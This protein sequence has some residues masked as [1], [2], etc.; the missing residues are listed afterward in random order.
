MRILVVDDDPDLRDILAYLLRRKGHAVTAASSGEVALSLFRKEPQDLLVLD[1]A[2]PR[3]DGLD[4]CRAVRESSSVPIIMLTVLGS[5]GDVIRSLDAGADD[6]LSKPFH[7]QELVARVE[8]LLRRSYRLHSLT[9][10]YP[11]RPPLAAAGIVMDPAKH[12][13]TKDGGPLALTRLE[14]KLLYEL[15]ANAGQVLSASDLLEHVW[16]YDADS[17]YDVVRV[18]I[19]RLRHK[20]EEDHARPQ[21]IR[22]VPGV[23]YSF[24]AGGVEIP[25]ALSQQS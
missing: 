17:S 20:L 12:A 1:I 13:V 3:M 25:A 18:H 14:F 5:E 8:A 7:H 23:G 15:M 16:G 4:L 24:R 9:S 21:L 11:A 6:H 10:V 19:S 22:T 2:M